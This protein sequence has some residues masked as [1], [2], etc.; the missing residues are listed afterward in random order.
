MKQDV[1]LW[2]QSTIVIG[3]N[4]RVH[5]YRYRGVRILFIWQKV[6]TTLNGWKSGISQIP[7]VKFRAPRGFT[8]SA[9]NGRKAE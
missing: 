2:L 6:T 8:N 9:W 5:N 3:R 4:Q 7:R 1:V